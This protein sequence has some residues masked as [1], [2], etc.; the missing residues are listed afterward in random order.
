M[1]DDPKG[2]SLWRIWYESGLLLVVLWVVESLGVT[3]YW[4]PVFDH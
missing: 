3:F 1:T 2:E 4:L